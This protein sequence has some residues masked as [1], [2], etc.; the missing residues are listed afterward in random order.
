MHERSLVLRLAGPLQSW[1]SSSQYNRRETDDRPTKSGIVGLLS[2][3]QGRRRTEPIDDLVELRLGIRIDQ[4]GSL[5][6]D[7]HTVSDLRGR[8]LL[9]A[10][11]SKSGAQRPSSTRKTTHVTERFYLQ[12]AVFVATVHG[13]AGLLSD[14]AAAITAPSFPLALGRR[15]CV[16]TQPML[17]RQG[18]STLWHGAHDEVIHRVPWQAGPDRRARA[19]RATVRLP[20]T[21][22]DESSFDTA[23]DVPVS[24]APVARGMRARPVRHTYAEVPTG[25]DVAADVSDDGHDPFSLLGW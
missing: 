24:F 4:P 12:D 23:A 10:A 18:D 20:V 2:A 25:L 9:S 1:G 11:V 8:P 17:L 15:S 7:Y 22:D 3:A 19:Q 16:P 5:L 21:C 14:L 6:R 13:E